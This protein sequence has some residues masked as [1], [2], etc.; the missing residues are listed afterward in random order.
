MPPHRGG[1]PIEALRV[2]AYRVPTEEEESDG[3]HTWTSTTAVVVEATGG[4]HTGLGWSYTH[5]A[6]ARLVDEA[7]APVVAGTDALDVPAAHLAMRRALRNVGT[8]GVGAAALSAVDT[9]LW[10]LKA[11]LFE[12]SL[13]GL[14]GQVRAACPVYGSGGFTSYGEERLRAQL[15]GWVEQGIERVKMKVG[16]EPSRDPERVRAARDAIGPRAGLFVD[17]N[18]ACTRKQALALA[19]RFAEHDVSWFEEPVSSDDRE[20]MRLLRDRAPAGMDIA[21]GEYGWEVF[22]FRDLLSAGAVDV[23]QADATRCGGFT[24][25]LQAAALSAAHGV[26]LSAHTAPALHVH[27]GCA[28]PSVIHLEYF[29]DHVRLESLLFDGVPGPAG[30]ALRPDGAAVG[31][32]LTLKERTA[33]PYRVA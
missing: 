1:V 17:A 20:G 28:A 33:Q 23:L 19:E 10:D 32:G 26:P 21:A 3:S 4:G 12:V 7:L 9:A 29:H 15:G 18:G 25:F 8:P 16:R 11:R 13:A 2:R 5:A 24:G 30:G 14:F 6:A 27:V 22:H 31:M